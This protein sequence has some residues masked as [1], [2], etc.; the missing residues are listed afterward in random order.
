[1]VRLTQAAG[2]MSAMM[3]HNIAN[4]VLYLLDRQTAGESAA[5]QASGEGQRFS[6]PSKSGGA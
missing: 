6:V 2:H 3:V 1:M 4:S 5:A